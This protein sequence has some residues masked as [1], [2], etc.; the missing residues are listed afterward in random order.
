MA[1]YR[2]RPTDASLDLKPETPSGGGFRLFVVKFQKKE[3][4]RKY[5]WI[6]SPWGKPGGFFYGFTDANT[7]LP[8]PG[9]IK[10]SIPL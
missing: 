6:P 3:T 2:W 9:E 4:G 8:S 10:A 1:W 5:A 7:L